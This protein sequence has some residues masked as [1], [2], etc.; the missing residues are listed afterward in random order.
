MESFK[1]PFRLHIPILITIG[2]LIRIPILLDP[3]LLIDGDEAIVGLMAS[4]WLKGG[5]FPTYFTGQQYGLSTLEAGIAALFFFVFGM[6]DWALKLSSL[7]IWL[8]G[9]VF[10]YKALAQFKPDKKN[11]AFIVTLILVTAPTWL[12]WGMKSR[13]GYISAFAISSVLLFILTKKGTWSN[14]RAIAIG[15]C[16]ALISQFHSLWIIS[17]LPVAAYFIFKPELFPQLKFILVGFLGVL[18]QLL[19]I[20][21]KQPNIW[22]PHLL[23]FDNEPIAWI[24]KLPDVLIHHFSGTYYLGS[25]KETQLMAVVFS[26]TVLL[27]LISTIVFVTYS[28]Y[29]TKNWLNLNT[30]LLVSILGNILITLF[31]IPGARY[32]LPVLTVILFLLFNISSD[33]K[34]LNVILPI[35]LLLLSITASLSKP[36][37]KK[38]DTY[39]F[40]T[41]LTK[42]TMTKL[43]SGLESEGIT[44]FFV[45]NGMGQYQIMFYGNGEINARYLLEQ[46]RMQ[47]RINAVAEAY[48]KKDKT[49]YVLLKTQDRQ[50]FNESKMKHLSETVSLV[51]NPAKNELEGF[52]F[53]TSDLK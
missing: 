29:K 33:Y 45:F 22:N 6:S 21:F 8:T 36:F 47:N 38:S 39:K 53:E 10:F 34:K 15:V 16:F 30:F 42:E 49:A 23:R 13:G 26:I 14:P 35:A 3:A 44:N 4:D 41:Q 17:I 11:I 51:I 19:L 24:L 43:L 50:H 31:L 9:A 5:A 37:S 20:K 18:L 7:S 28:N 46:D 27:L 2:I 32:L 25:L 48:N 12:Y 52:G 1:I 40:E